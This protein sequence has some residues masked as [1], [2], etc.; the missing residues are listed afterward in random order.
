[1]HLPMAEHSPARRPVI[2]AM[3]NVVHHN[4]A[5]TTL[6]GSSAMSQRKAARAARLEREMVEQRRLFEQKVG[7]S[8][9]A[10][11]CFASAT[12]M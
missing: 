12:A 5:D 3:G 4:Y 10:S 1:M 8:L 9:L 7:G 6:S 11:A 2:D